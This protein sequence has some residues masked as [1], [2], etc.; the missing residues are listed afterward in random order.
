MTKYKIKPIEIEAIQ[1]RWDNWEEVCDFVPKKQLGNK[2]YIED[3]EELDEGYTSDT[4]GLKIRTLQGEKT[5]IE[6]DYIIKNAKGE[7]FI[8][9]QNDFEVTYE[10]A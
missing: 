8:S 10:K 9:K 3:G 5:I 1:L 6:C 7:V 2:V 4:I